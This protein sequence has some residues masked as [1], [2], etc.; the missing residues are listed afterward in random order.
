[1]GYCLQI[2][3]DPFF[4]TKQYAKHEP[5]FNLIPISIKDFVKKIE[6]TKSFKKAFGE[7]A[8]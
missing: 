3:P 2:S 4:D 1:V 6:E 8:K 5:D 7:L